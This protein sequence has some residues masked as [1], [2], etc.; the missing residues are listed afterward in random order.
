MNT[1][2]YVTD[3]NI[4][5]VE[6][7]P[8]DGTRYNYFFVSLPDEAKLGS[9]NAVLMGFKQ[10]TNFTA[11]S[12]ILDKTKHYSY[13]KEKFGCSKYDAVFTA[14]FL[15]TFGK[16]IK[17]ILHFC[18]SLDIQERELTDEEITALKEHFVENN[19]TFDGV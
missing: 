12:V 18:R 13:I 15:N 6:L 16:E 8:G 3:R 4:I 5:Y 1:I 7:Q 2:R 11:Y 14:W 9:E 10:S 17:E 19:L